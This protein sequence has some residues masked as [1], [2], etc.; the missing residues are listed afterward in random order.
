MYD[1]SETTAEP[2]EVLDV[3]VNRGVDG[4]E[5]ILSLEVHTT[6]DG[7][8]QEKVRERR[9]SLNLTVSDSKLYTTEMATEE[10]NKLGLKLGCKID[11]KGLVL[12][13]TIS[14]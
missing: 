1:A 13:L 12:F 2:G 3:V 9:K 8:T 10:L 14:I 5:E 4:R 11:E 7:F 6:T